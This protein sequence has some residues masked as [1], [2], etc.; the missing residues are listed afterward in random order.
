M[1]IE[2]KFL[3]KGDYKRE[4]YSYAHIVQGYICS[5][6]ERVVRVRLQGDAGFLTIKGATDDTGM[7]RY[8][9]EKK[10]TQTEAEE[11]LQLC[12][13]HTMIEKV[14]YYVIGNTHTFEV[15]EFKRDNE[16]LTVAEVELL[17]PDETIDLP[18]FIGK[19]ITGDS[20]YY[21]SQLA[22]YPYNTWKRS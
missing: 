22:R 2:R 14:R 19:E 20:R 5:D 8:E 21:N 16:G 11:L 18:S 12:E 1:E 10:L 3:V 4:A 17:Y 9:W 6:P 15:D 13:P 7:S